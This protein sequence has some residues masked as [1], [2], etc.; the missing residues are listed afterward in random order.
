MKKAQSCMDAW[1]QTRTCDPKSNDMKY[2]VLLME[3]IQNMV[4]GFHSLFTD[5][6]KKKLARYMQKLGFDDVAATFYD[7]HPESG[8]G[9]EQLSVHTTSVRFQLE[10][11]GHLLKRDERTD[12]DPRVDHFIP[13]T[14]QRELL[15]AVDNNESAVIVAPTSSGRPAKGRAVY[16]VFTRDYRFNALNSQILVTV[17]QCLEILFLSPHKQDWTKNVKYVIFDEVHCLGQESG[18]EVW[19]HLLLL[20]RCPF[21]A[22]SATIGNPHDL[23]DWLQ[24]A[25]DFREQQ[26]KQ[27]SGGKLRNSYRIRLGEGGYIIF[28]FAKPGVHGGM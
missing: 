7:L 26:D 25:Q 11:M 14:W 8:K 23:M 9:S 17:P 18:A 1:Q 24:A 21:L 6:D 12:A 20:I 28:L 5:K 3:S 15:D 22:L 16:G 2:P 13:D 27:D 10:H 4:Q 19:E